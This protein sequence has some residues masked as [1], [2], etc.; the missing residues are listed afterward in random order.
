[1]KI[2]LNLCRA[3]KS[4]FVIDLSSYMHDKLQL[5]WRWFGKVPRKK[6]DFLELLDNVSSFVFRPYIAL[7][8]SFE[9]VMFYTDVVCGKTVA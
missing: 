1:M 4:R 9:S 5:V 3:A 6:R 7:P 2:S 8:E